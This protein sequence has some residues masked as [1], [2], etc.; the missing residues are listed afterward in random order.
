MCGIIGF[1]GRDKC[2]PKIIHGL[3]ALEY[4]GYD[5]AGIA[6]FKDGKIETIKE[7]GKIA[8][9]K[10]LLNFIYFCFSTFINVHIMHIYALISHILSF[11]TVYIIYV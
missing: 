4:R 6:Y 9:L 1:I 2:I 11:W 10:K 3:E 7:E 5:S 8:N